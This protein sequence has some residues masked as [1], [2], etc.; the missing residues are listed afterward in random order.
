MKNKMFNDITFLLLDRI[1]EKKK[2]KNINNPYSNIQELV[3]ERNQQREI[4]VK[5]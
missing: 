1:N 4:S 5:K 2:K 3:C